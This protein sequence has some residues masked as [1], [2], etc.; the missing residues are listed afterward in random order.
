[1]TL[2][3]VRDELRSH[4]VT[5]RKTRGEYRV[6]LREGNENTAYYTDDLTD[7]YDTGLDMRRRVHRYL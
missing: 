2:S 5:I 6:N 3:Q 4:N 1:M 7:A